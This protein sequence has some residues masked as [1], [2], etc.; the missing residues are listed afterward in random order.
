MKI[1]KT[2]EENA[3]EVI[4]FW[5]GVGR[6]GFAQWRSEAFKRMPLVIDR[7]FKN[8]IEPKEFREP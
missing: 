1:L 5:G 7:D 8:S 3:S 6:A 4:R 2:L